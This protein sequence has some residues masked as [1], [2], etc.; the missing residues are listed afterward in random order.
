MNVLFTGCSYTAG[1]GWPEQKQDLH[2]WVNILHKQLWPTHKIINLGISGNNNQGIFQSTIEQLTKQ[3]IDVAIVQ[4][5]CFP[6]YM[7]DIGFELYSTKLNV[8]P[9]KVPCEFNLNSK[10]ISKSYVKDF[11]N[12]LLY[13]HHEQPEIVQLIKYVNCLIDLARITKTKIYFVNGICPWDNNFFVRKQNV[14]PE[15][16]T[17]FTKQLLNVKN[18]N[19]EEI[20]KLYNL[21]HNQYSNAGTIQ[22]QYW[23]NLYNSLQQNRIDTNNDNK[24]PGT[25]SNQNY[26]QMLADSIQNSTQG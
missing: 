6:R 17:D 14:L 15:G 11:I 19:D 22:K 9:N 24:H 8:Y 13:L 2:L 26:A 1:E 25:I 20:L 16:Y 10:Q 23:L 12:K 7:F 21:M 5:T 4:W 3:D 18:R